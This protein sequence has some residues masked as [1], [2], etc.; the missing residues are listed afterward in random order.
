[1]KLP[2]LLT[3][4]QAADILQLS[5]DTI[6]RL[7]AAGKIP[8]IKY[9]KCWRIRIED[10]IIPPTTLRDQ[11]ASQDHRWKGIAHGLVRETREK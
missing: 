11:A 10:V 7:L 3:V 4:D 9:G 2:Q 6:Y 5:R 8:G 1:M